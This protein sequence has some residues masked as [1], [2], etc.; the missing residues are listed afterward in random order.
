MLCWALTFLWSVLSVILVFFGQDLIINFYTPDKTVQ[1]S[2]KPAWYV[3]SI[4][5]F[6]DCMQVV[7]S[8]V[9][10]GLGMVKTI[11]Y[12]TV[13][14]YWVFGIPIAWFLTFE[15]GW[16]LEGLWYGPTIACALNY[17]FYEFI[18]RT[19]DWTKR[20]Q[21]I[22]EKMDKEKERDEATLAKKSAEREKEKSSERK[23]ETDTDKVDQKNNAIN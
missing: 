7:T 6:F 17:V 5:T 16:K 22:K 15:M 10:S 12:F 11:K 4:F 21:E 9:I 18:I 23:T 3:L 13:I 8:Y 1:A 2:I 14:S 19:T 20:A